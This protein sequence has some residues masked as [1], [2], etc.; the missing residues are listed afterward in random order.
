MRLIKIARDGMNIEE[1]RSIVLK[2]QILSTIGRM[3]RIRL[4]FFYLMVKIVDLM[5]LV[6]INVAY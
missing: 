6:N 5:G 1:C 4:L 3:R 2:I